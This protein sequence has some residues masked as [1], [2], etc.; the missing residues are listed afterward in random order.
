MNRETKKTQISKWEP[1]VSEFAR[2]PW[3]SE[4]MNSIENGETGIQAYRK[5]VKE[6][7]S[8]PSDKEKVIVVYGPTA[9]WKT[10]LSLDIWTELRE[11]G[12][13]PFIISAD[14][15]QIYKWMD[16]GTGKVKKEEMRW[17]LHLM[18]DIIEPTEKFSVVDF[19]ERVE[20]SELWKRWKSGEEKLIPIICGWTGLYV[21]SIIFERSYPTIPADW[22]LRRELEE[23]RIQNGN[24]AL[25]KKLYE[26]D[27]SYAKTLHPNDRHYIIRGIEVYTKSGRSKME[28]QDTPT[29]K[30]STLFL[31]PY[32]SNREKLYEKINARIEEMFEIWLVKEV[33][34]I[35]D[36]LS[37]E[38][39]H[40][41][42]KTHCPWLATIGYAEVVE[43][44][45]W[46][47]S[48]DECKN[49]VKQHNRNYAKRQITW[50]KKYGSS[51]NC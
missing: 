19:R 24:E 27:P 48:L 17:I 3:I 31:T 33:E 21:D 35:L 11:S 32:D 38:L 15:R 47:I 43:Y 42:N 2:T 8:I 9:C 39:L 23:F 45:E 5:R 29:L 30:Y 6:F 50:N 7:M 14:S 22:E 37:R 49:L 44:I 18:L 28:I 40:V 13:S 4:E 20:N 41:C 34:Y 36:N 16:I 26:I 25:W 10:G 12:F 51:N 46:K 1:V